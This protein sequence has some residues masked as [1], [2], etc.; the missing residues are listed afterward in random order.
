MGT[1]PLED[2]ALPLKVGTGHTTPNYLA[3]DMDET[4]ILT[5]TLDANQV[6]YLYNK[7]DANTAA[8]TA[9]EVTLA[10]PSTT[11]EGAVAR[12]TIGDCDGNTNY[13]I[14]TS[15]TP[16]A[17]GAITTPCTEAVGGAVY[18][19]L[20]SGGNTL[21]FYFGDGATTAVSGPSLSVTRS[22]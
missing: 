22:D 17:P 16:P 21:Y 18:N 15:A 14:T 8:P 13:T 6:E 5:S 3:G 7:G 20:S 2:V 19:S 10:E 12:F 11:V 1:D 9:I 4:L